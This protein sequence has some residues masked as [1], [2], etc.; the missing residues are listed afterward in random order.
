MKIQYLKYLPHQQECD[1]S[2]NELMNWVKN[3]YKQKVVQKITLADSSY[4]KIPNTNVSIDLTPFNKFSKGTG[5][6]E[7]HGFL[8]KN[9][10]ENAIY[11][12]S[13]LKLKNNSISNL[14]KLSY[15]FMKPFLIL[16]G[17]SS[18]AY[19][20]DDA[21]F[22]RLN[23][24]YFDDSNKYLKRFTNKSLGL[25]KLVKLVEKY[26]NVFIYILERFGVILNKTEFTKLGRRDYTIYEKIIKLESSNTCV[27]KSLTPTNTRRLISK[28]IEKSNHELSKDEYYD[29]LN[30]MLFIDDFLKC[31]TAFGII[32]TPFEL[33]YPSTLNTYKAH[34]TRCKVSYKKHFSK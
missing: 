19:S 17:S 23:R 25:E 11:Q 14:C 13:F 2:G 29:M 10:S 27:Q 31:M 32:H 15:Y 34:K 6:Y 26:A 1:L 9:S 20:F 5:W 8:P 18:I 30:Y 28:I 21:A 7:S 22:D 3:L 33:Q 12:K 4:Y 24:E 16:N